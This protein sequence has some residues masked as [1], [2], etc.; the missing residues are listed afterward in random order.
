MSLLWYFKSLLVGTSFRYN[1][2][3][4]QK[5][6]WKFGLIKW[7]MHWLLVIR[8]FILLY[9]FLL[10]T[11]LLALKGCN[12]V[13]TTIWRYISCP[14]YSIDLSCMSWFSATFCHLFPDLIVRV[15]I[16]SS[17][18]RLLLQVLSGCDIF[19]S[20]RVTFE[21]GLVWSFSWLMNRCWLLLLL[22]L[23]IHLLNYNL[24]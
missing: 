18:P 12:F 10:F 5:V 24:S 17:W 9:L 4:S 16:I 23:M 21:R 1:W 6:F 15:C 14:I 7:E 3:R 19:F 11:A 13:F 2:K 22:L 20:R 8:R